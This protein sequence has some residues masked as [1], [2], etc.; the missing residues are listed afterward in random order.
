MLTAIMRK[1]VIPSPF[2]GLHLLPTW[3]LQK[4]AAS[5]AA[6]FAM[7]ASCKRY[8]YKQCTVIDIKTTLTLRGTRRGS[9]PWRMACWRPSV[10]PPC[11][12]TVWHSLSGGPCQLT[13]TKRKK[14]KMPELV[15]Q[16]HLGVKHHK[17]HENLKS[18][19]KFTTYENKW[20]KSI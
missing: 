1:W 2:R 6:S 4:V 20:N 10:A 7:A 16:F 9:L 13:W 3:W 12:S 8:R 14:T 17:I 11:R 15:C 19:N 5:D 18:T